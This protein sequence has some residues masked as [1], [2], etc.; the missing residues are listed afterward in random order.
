MVHFF[1]DQGK[2]IPAMAGV[3][4][5]VP[6]MTPSPRRYG[7]D[8]FGLPLLLTQMPRPQNL[9]MQPPKRTEYVPLK[10]PETK[11][12]EEYREP[13]EE[14]YFRQFSPDHFKYKAISPERK[15]EKLK[16]L[17]KIPLLHDIETYEG[18]DTFTNL[19]QT[20]SRKADEVINPFEE[21][22]ES[23]GIFEETPPQLASPDYISE[24]DLEISPTLSPPKRYNLKKDL[25]K[26]KIEFEEPYSADEN[27]V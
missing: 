26:R 15:L 14:E 6:R 24:T 21:L 19:E 16:P 18:Q 23:I 25:I 3:P 7:Y 9:A 10:S 11:T 17:Q 22:D 5:T 13:T 12:D 27:E 20:Q 4:I 1:K 8:E 2:A